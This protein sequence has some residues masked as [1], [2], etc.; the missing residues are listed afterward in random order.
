MTLVVLGDE[1]L[2]VFLLARVAENL[3]QEPVSNKK[4]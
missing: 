4:P 2:L 1:F 3:L